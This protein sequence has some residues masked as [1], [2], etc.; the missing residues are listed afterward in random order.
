MKHVLTYHV[1]GLLCLGLVEFSCVN[2]P[3]TTGPVIGDPPRLFSFNS[4][5]ARIGDT[6]C[7]V[8]SGLD[9]NAANDSVF[10]AGNAGRRIGATVYSV[11]ATD[12]IDTIFVIVPSN[13]RTG[14]IVVHVNA[15]SDSSKTSITID[16]LPIPSLTG[17]FPVSGPSGTV[18]KIFGAHISPVLGTTAVLV[19]GSAARI[20]QAYPDSIIIRLANSPGSITLRQGCS[21]MTAPGTFSVIPRT[22]VIDSFK[23]IAGLPGATIDTIMGSGFG[24]DT[25]GVRV[26]YGGVEGVALSVSPTKIIAVVPAGA[27]TGQVGVRI[28][29][30]S[31]KSAAS[32][33]VALPRKFSTLMLSSMH[34]PAAL[35]N[36]DS[37]ASYAW[38]DTGF[39]SFP[40]S[41]HV[42]IAKDSFLLSDTLTFVYQ[43]PPNQIFSC[44]ETIVIQ[45]AL[46]VVTQSIPWLVM[47]YTD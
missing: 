36:Y 3:A 34:V 9:K 46:N 40:N 32:F 35:Y 47:S 7:I 1:V 38:D 26:E 42:T 30:D 18:I 11:H 28:F 24:Y 10:F 20:L 8:G 25:A 13:A 12:S 2:K 14:A 44:T 15:R 5:C 21:S 17:F 4:S 41:P 16:T 39:V 19:G 33:L 37:G 43:T 31:A 22:I 45:C 27:S 23:P 29:S 6:L